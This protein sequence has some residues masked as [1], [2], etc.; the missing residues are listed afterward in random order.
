MQRRG[1]SGRPA[2]SRRTPGPKALKSSKLSSANLQDQVAALRRDLKEAREQQ[3]AAS[4]VLKVISRSPGELGSA[5]NAMLENATHIC[6]ASYGIMFL[7]EGTG[8]RTAAMHNLPRA[9][10]EERQRSALIQPTPEDPLSHLAT[11]K[12][13]VHI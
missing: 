1:E 13:K 3:T 7:C 11:T 9:L 8:F 10:A 6:D 2:K 5:F 4:E 12:Q